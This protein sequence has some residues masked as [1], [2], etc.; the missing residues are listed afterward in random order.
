[1][2]LYAERVKKIQSL[3]KKNSL[4]LFIIP[5]FDI[6][7]SEYPARCFL[8]REFISGFKG[9]AGTL[10]IFAK[11]AFFSKRWSL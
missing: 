3:M 4:D 1:M 2:S 10:L 8:E 7:L 11:E 5:S 6:H 9:S